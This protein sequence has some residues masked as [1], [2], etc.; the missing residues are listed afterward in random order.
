MTKN[1]G[2][3]RFDEP[4]AIITPEEIVEPL[5]NFIEFV[6][7]I[8]GFGRSQQLIET[9][10]NLERVNREGV[11]VQTRCCLTRTMHLTKARRVP[12][13]GGEIAA[14]LDLL[15]IKGNIL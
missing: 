2:L 8:S 1:F 10:E 7:A 4:I 15:F 9:G 13:F 6:F 12:K 3:G 14:F 11:L 5:H